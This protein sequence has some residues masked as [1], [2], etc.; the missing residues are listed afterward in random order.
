MF[1]ATLVV[2]DWVVIRPLF[3]E[4]PR[5]D[6]PVLVDQAS[7]AFLQGDLGPG[8]HPVRDDLRSSPWPRPDWRAAVAALLALVVL[9][10]LYL[11]ADYL[12]AAGYALLLAP[13][14]ADVAFRWLVPEE[15]FPVSYRRRATPPT[16]TWAAS[17]GSRSWPWPTSSA[18]RSPRSRSSAGG[19]GRL[20]P[21]A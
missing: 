1:L 21:C 15:G 4:L 18:S 19:L 6:V 3:V 8:H 17:A 12:S 5:P 2:T 10:E 11:A 20:L 7:Y 16:W 13:C 9:A 14:L